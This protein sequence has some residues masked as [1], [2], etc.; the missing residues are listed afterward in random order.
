[1]KAKYVFKGHHVPK[2]VDLSVVIRAAKLYEI[3]S[4]KEM[5]CAF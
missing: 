2:S 3:S 5:L 4:D 1:M